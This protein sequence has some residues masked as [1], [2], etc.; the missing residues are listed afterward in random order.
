MRKAGTILCALVIGLL[1]PLIIFEFSFYSRAASSKDYRACAVTDNKMESRDTAV[2]LTPGDLAIVTPTN[3][4]SLKKNEV[5]AYRDAAGQTKIRRIVK[6]IRPKKGKGKDKKEDK[7]ADP[8]GF[9]VKG[10]AEDTPTDDCYEVAP[11][12]VLGRF[13]LKVDNGA[14]KYYFYS[15]AGGL[16]TCGILP[17]LIIL[18]LSAVLILLNRPKKPEHQEPEY[19]PEDFSLSVSDGTE[20]E[21]KLEYDEN[22]PIHLVQG[23]VLKK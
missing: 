18:A 2:S 3:A 9:K 23:R 10:D 22:S 13:S 17:I 21:E 14:K 5:I 4:L 15:N 11:N 12:E 1:I 16:I 19:S 7:N 20:P 6:V 8:T